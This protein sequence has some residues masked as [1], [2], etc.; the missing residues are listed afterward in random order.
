MVG[1]LVEHH[2]QRL[3]D[4]ADEGLVGAEEE[5]ER[6]LEPEA[7]PFE[8]MDDRRVGGQPQRL[9]IEQEADMVGAA[10][11]LGV[12]RAPAGGG[13]ERDLDPR[14]AD[15]RADDADEGD[16]PVHPPRSL[17]ARAEIEDLRDRAVGVGQPG[18]EDRAC[19]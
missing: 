10:G 5:M 17:E 16:R 19:S 4:V 2:R 8:Q 1:G 14:R 11:P 18:R 7:A 6:L 9:G 15:D 3:V 12:A 13:I